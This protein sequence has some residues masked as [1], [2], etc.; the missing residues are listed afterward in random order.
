[1]RYLTSFILILS[2]LNSL[3]PA[4][5]ETL[6]FPGAEGFGQFTKGGRGGRVIEVINLNDSGP[7]SFRDAVEAL[8]PR[9]VVFRVGGMILLDPIKKGPRVSSPF[10]TIAGQIAP[11]D[12]E[13]SESDIGKS[14]PIQYLYRSVRDEKPYA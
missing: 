8:G 2:A 1:M 4:Q 11:G 12:G 3:A 14:L 6:A 9:T 13:Q 5:A 10:I 7:G